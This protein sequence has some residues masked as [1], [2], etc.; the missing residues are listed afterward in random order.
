MHEVEGDGVTVILN[1]FA[2]PV[3]EASEAAHAHTHC[4]I[5]TLNITG[6]NVLRVRISTNCGCTASD[7]GCRAVTCLREIVRHAVNLHQHAVVDVS[8]ESI[9]NGINV[10]PMTVCGEL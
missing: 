2:K 9:F 5:L 4:E 6:G 3:R 1:L 7:A 8:P 10:N